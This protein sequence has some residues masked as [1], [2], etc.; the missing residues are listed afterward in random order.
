MNDFSAMKKELI[1]IFKKTEENKTED[2]SHIYINLETP[3][4]IM[5]KTC[6]KDFEIDYDYNDYIYISGYEEQDGTDYEMV[7]IPFLNIKSIDMKIEE[8]EYLYCITYFDKT[9]LSIIIQIL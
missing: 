9:K 6:V 8:D 4:N 5:V 7:K 1:E 2:N 3:N